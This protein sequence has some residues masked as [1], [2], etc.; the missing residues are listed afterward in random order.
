MPKAPKEVE[1]IITHKGPKE[2]RMTASEQKRRTAR[3]MSYKDK[4]RAFYF[5][6]GGLFA[7]AIIGTLSFFGV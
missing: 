4:E 3:L 5:L 6:S 7:C 1:E 2:Y